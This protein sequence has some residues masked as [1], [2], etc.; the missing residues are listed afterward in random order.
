MAKSRKHG[1]PKGRQKPGGT[2]KE[3]IVLLP[4]TYNDGTRVTEGS[5]ESIYGEIFAAF[6]GWTIEG[7]VRGAYRMRTGQKRVEALQKVSIVLDESQVPDLEAMIGRWAAELGQ[8]AMLL[9]VT[10]HVIKFIPPRRE[11]EEQ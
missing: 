8:E 6:H 11:E 10:D 2:P 4:L 5:L 7:A 1:K 9:R 3:A